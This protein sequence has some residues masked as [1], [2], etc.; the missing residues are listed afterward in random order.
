MMRVALAIG[1]TM[2]HEKAAD[3]ALATA[4]S[5]AERCV[6]AGASLWLRAWAAGKASDAWVL[7]AAL[8][9]RAPRL[10]AG[11]VAAFPAPTR[12]S[13]IEDLLV[14]DNLAGGRVELAFAPDA[15]PEA[16]TEVCAALRGDALSRPDPGGT[17]RSFMLTPRPAR[18]A[19][20]TWVPLTGPSMPPGALMAWQLTSGAG[21]QSPAVVVRA[22]SF[23]RTA[24]ADGAAAADTYPVIDLGPRP[25]ID[26]VDRVLR[27][28]E[29]GR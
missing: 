27:R 23:G 1:L 24:A 4:L 21:G 19:I 13:D 28:A 25:S 12:V 10:T 7:L 29:G 20:P 18:G 9:E 11:V 22:E 26:D 6:A 5:V 17:A 16:I 8:L 14:V 2:P 15:G 3:R